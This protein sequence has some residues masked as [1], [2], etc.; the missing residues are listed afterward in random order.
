VLAAVA[1][2]AS[3]GASPA[4]PSTS[5]PP[6]PSTSAA[7]PGG[8]ARTLA[9]SPSGAAR[10]VASPAA[11]PGL[12]GS[13]TGAPLKSQLAAAVQGGAS[14][15]VAAGPLTGKSLAG[16]PAT[17]NQA[18]PPAFYAMTLTSVRTLRGPAIASGSTAWIPG[19]AHG[20]T[21]TPENSALLAPGGRL[22]AIAWPKDVTRDP[23]GPVLQLAPIVAADVV[24][25]P[26]VCWNLDG[27]QPDQYQ[28]STPLRP[29][30]GGANFGGTHQAAENGLYTVPLATVERIAAAA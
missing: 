13:C 19:P 7:S 27:L 4:G 3:P 9:S 12:A 29:V 28:A 8:A 26:D 15:I 14:L 6:S 17:G 10:T 1:C 23:V 2:T 18:G 30:P 16:K 20:T 21:A 22:F 24:F 11:A 5:S 25:T